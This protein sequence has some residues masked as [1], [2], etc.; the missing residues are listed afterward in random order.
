MADV[1]NLIADMVRSGV[2]ADL[3]GRTAEALATRPPI[4]VKDE[5]AERRREA[6]KVRK[7]ELRLR[8]SAEVGGTSEVPPP[9]LDK[10][11]PHT[12][13]ELIPSAPASP[14]RGEFDQFWAVFPNKVG[15][16]DASKA[17]AK[18]IQRVDF[19]TM[20]AGLRRYVAKTDDRPWC[21]PATWLNQ[22][23][24]ADEPASVARA[25][26]SATRSG[27]LGSMFG[28]MREHLENGQGN[29]SFGDRPS[30]APVLSLPH[31]RAG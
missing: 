18:A 27:G 25:G 20:L 15:K 3:I 30:G 1:A 2:D 31:R 24:W 23:R 16:A 10:K 12:P 14:A 8:K 21:N 4:L 7:A 9:S 29:G 19:E 22:D 5:A 6:D 17:F 26:P 11:A 28:Q 13:K